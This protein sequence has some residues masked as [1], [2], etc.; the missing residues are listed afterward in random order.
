MGGAVTDAA[1]IL[2]PADTPERPASPQP[3]DS[4]AIATT[5]V[6]HSLVGYQLLPDAAPVVAP[7][8]ASIRHLALEYDL[9]SADPAHSSLTVTTPHQADG[10]DTALITVT[11]RDAR[12]QPFSWQP[13]LGHGYRPR[14]QP[15][16]HLRPDRRRRGFYGYANQP[17]G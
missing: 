15:D 13:G 5:A 10:L 4:E 12:R 6:D 7:A 8:F 2:V 16:P 9:L 11:A 3:L 1:P 14:Q 17:A